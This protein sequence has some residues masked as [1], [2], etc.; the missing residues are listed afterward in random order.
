MLFTNFSF[1]K[2]SSTK[3]QLISKRLFNFFNSPKKPTKN[4]CSS[5]L[6][7]AKIRTFKFVYLKNLRH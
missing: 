1:V 7:R 6:S 2:H 4:F 3:G 5:R